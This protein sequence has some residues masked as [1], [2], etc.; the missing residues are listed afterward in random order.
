MRFFLFLCVSISLLVSG[1][2]Q[3]GE[4]MT[5]VIQSSD[6]VRV[7]VNREPDLNASGQ[8]SK[9]GTL[10]IPLIGDVKLSGKSTA[11]AKSFIEAKF[12]DGYLVRPE[13]TVFITKRVEHIVTV[14]GKVT[15]PGVFKIPHG[16]PLSL[17]QVVSMAGGATD[18]A[19]LRK[20]TLR[21]GLKG[22]TYVIDLK[23]IMQNK[24][25]D[26]VLQK[27]DFIFIPEGIF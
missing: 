10:S 21:R 8:L 4:N 12:R 14:N 11:S 3:E 1:F 18:V 17:R 2:G 23:K 15:S 13:V 20:V 26:I 7:T 9:N 27:D 5:G 19:N 22:Q 6:M 25:Q 24:A 16:Q